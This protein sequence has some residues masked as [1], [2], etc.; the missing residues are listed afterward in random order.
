LW[1]KRKEEKVD[2]VHTTT[3]VVDHIHCPIPSSLFITL[4]TP[5]YLQASSDSAA[6]ACMRLTRM[7]LLVIAKAAEPI[8]PLLRL[9]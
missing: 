3:P 1:W 8:G 9:L 2:G 5:L 6:N 4:A 7:Y